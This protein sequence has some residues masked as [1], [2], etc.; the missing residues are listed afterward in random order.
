[1]PF[2][3]QDDAG[4]THR[5]RQVA[6]VDRDGALAAG[7]GEGGASLP[8]HFLDATRMDHVAV[9]DRELSPPEGYVISFVKLHHH[10]LGSPTLWG[11]ASTFLPQRDLCCG[12]LRHGV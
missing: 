5:H 7:L 10:R 9:E 3:D 11:Q 12:N 8:P 2:R 6:L 1:M 4:E